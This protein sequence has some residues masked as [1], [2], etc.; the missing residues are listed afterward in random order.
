MKEIGFTTVTFRPKT[1]REICELAKQNNITCIEWGGDVHLPPQDKDALA[2]VIALQKE[3]G[4]TATSYGSYYRLGEENY[5]LWRDIVSTAEAIGAGIIRI[6]QGSLSSFKVDANTMQAMVKEM[7]QLADM[8]AEKDI[9]VACEF[10]NNTNND[11]GTSC[12]AFIQAVNKANVKTYWQPFSTD[13][14]IENLKATLPYL[15]C[16]H[17]FEWDANYDRFPL[18]RGQEKWGTFM[19]IIDQAGISPHY[20][21]E[22]VNDDC[23]GQF[24][25][26]A[27]VLKEWV[28]Q[29]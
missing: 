16:V 8:A 17:V 26:D 14:D 11:N 2:E 21:M 4:L 28:R 27:A 1:R 6:W 24:A 20:I 22:F 25:K 12:V 13:A 18:E 15:V 19:D 10:H 7:Q 23:D 29:R 9:T 3:F 5:I